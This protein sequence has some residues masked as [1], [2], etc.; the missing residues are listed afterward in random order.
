MRSGAKKGT[1]QGR[2]GWQGSPCYCMLLARVFWSLGSPFWPA[3]CDLV[4]RKVHGRG[5]WVGGGDLAVA[6]LQ[7]RS[8]Q[9][10]AD[11]WVSSEP[12]LA[13]VFKYVTSL[14]LLDWSNLCIDDLPLCI[15]V[16]V[17]LC[18][19][20][21]MQVYVYACMCEMYLCKRVWCICM[22]VCNKNK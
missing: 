4:P 11:S 19:C 12:R 20:L 14:Q 7:P 6:G 10:I 21:C 13:S 22:H 8:Q 18:V 16:W 5:G 3:A 17:S 1:W 15:H 9:S 2:V